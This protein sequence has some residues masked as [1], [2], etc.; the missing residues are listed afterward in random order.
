MELLRMKKWRI[1]DAIFPHLEALFANGYKNNELVCYLLMKNHVDDAFEYFMKINNENTN[2]SNPVEDTTNYEL[3]TNQNLISKMLYIL[4]SKRKT[5]QA[6]TLVREILPQ[7]RYPKAL[8][9]PLKQTRLSIQPDSLLQKNIV[10]TLEKAKLRK[11]VESLGYSFPKRNV[12]QYNSALVE[13][14]KRNDH[15]NAKAVLDEMLH[16]NIKI[17]LKM[18]CTILSFRLEY[19]SLKDGK[20]V[21]QHVLLN[22]LTPDIRFF[23]VWLE[24]EILDS[25]ITNTNCDSTADTRNLKSKV[26]ELLP[27]SLNLLKKKQEQITHLINNVTEPDSKTYSLLLYTNQEHLV[28]NVKDCDYYSNV[29]PALLDIDYQRAKSE[30]LEGIKHEKL[31]RFITNSM[32]QKTADLSEKSFLLYTMYKHEYA[33][34]KPLLATVLE[35]LIDNHIYWCIVLIPQLDYWKDGNRLFA[36]VVYQIPKVNFYDSGLDAKEAIGKLVDILY[37]NKSDTIPLEM[38]FPYLV[39]IVRDLCKAHHKNKFPSLPPAKRLVFKKEKLQPLP[40]S[41]ELQ[42]ITKEPIKTV[43]TVIGELFKDVDELVFGIGDGTVWWDDLKK[44]Q[45]QLLREVVKQEW[46]NGYLSRPFV[47]KMVHNINGFESE[48]DWFKREERIIEYIQLAKRV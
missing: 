26:K 31:N 34:P 17:D 23:N 11:I 5:K 48:K 37:Y 8:M 27:D 7:I 33:F 25:I 22:G 46:S 41:E 4:S 24:R 39:H 44:T 28:A 1:D 45:K 10:Y 38:A 32:L 43:T 20:S 13:S 16:N 36:K 3:I 35:K 2:Y 30:F 12:A 15:L 42:K 14:L 18:Y 19:G 29:I 21:Y 6:L 47:N 40:P 9:I